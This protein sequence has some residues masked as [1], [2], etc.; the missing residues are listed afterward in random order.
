MK[1]EEVSDADEKEDAVQMTFPKIKVEPEV[2]CMSVFALLGRYHKYV[3]VQIIS[4]ISICLSVHMNQLPC[5]HWIL[6]SFF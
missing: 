1:S 2:S 5:V 3:E 6:R 4:F